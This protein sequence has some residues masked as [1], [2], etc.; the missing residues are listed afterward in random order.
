MIL[1]DR[2][3]KNY[4]KNNKPALNRASIHVGAG[5]FVIIVGT[6][7]ADRQPLQLARDW[8]HKLTFEYP[9]FRHN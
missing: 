7:Y 3:T 4:G 1:L 2:V 8:R 5:E 6:P 9:I